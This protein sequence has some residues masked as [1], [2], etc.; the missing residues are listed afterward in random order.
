MDRGLHLDDLRIGVNG[1]EMIAL[2]QR[3]APGDVLTVMGPSGCGKSTLLAAIAGTIDPAFSVS[4]HVRLDGRD[5]TGLPP[6][7][8]QIGLLFQDALMFPHLSVGQNLAF[9]IP[10]TVRRRERE[11][12]V[13][14]AL[15]EIGL[16]GY[17]ARDPATLSGG[18]R[19]RVALMRCLLSQPRAVLLDEPFSKLDTALRDQM[20]ALTR[21]LT[22]DL[23]VILVTHDPEDAEAMEGMVLQA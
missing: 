18:Q 20:R 16:A 13:H 14:R 6:E 10:S 11:A 9:G 7:Q 21:R 12:R 2:S 1:A 3:V 5:V 15:E 23:P 4:G 22:R 19:A 8:R 17:A